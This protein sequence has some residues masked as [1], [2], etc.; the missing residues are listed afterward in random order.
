MFAKSRNGKSV[1]Y[2]HISGEHLQQPDLDDLLVEQLQS[3]GLKVYEHHINVEAYWQYRSNTQYPADY[4]G[5]GLDP[6]ANFTEKTLEHYVSTEL[7]DFKPQHTFVDIAACTS[8]F[9]AIVKEKYGL[10]KIYQQDLVYPLGMHGNRIGGM[11]HQIDLPDESIDRVTLHCSLE[12]FEDNSDT[13][14]FQ[15]MQRKLKPGGKIIVLPFY[16]ALEHT[17]HVDPVYNLLKRHHPNIDANARLR[18]CNWYQ[19][20]S[21]HYEPKSLQSRILQAVPKLQLSVF[22]IKNFRKVHQSCYLRFAAV[23]T[24]STAS[25]FT[26]TR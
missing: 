23:F 5:G 18:Y 6:K 7:L 17:N 12:H 13:L 15:A 20:F 25:L 22:C 8:P 19:F 14:F 1:K 10:Q 11:A 26:A 3:L 24:K 9:A 4:Y 21:R 16:I 2:G